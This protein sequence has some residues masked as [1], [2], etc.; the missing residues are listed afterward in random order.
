MR[1]A[2]SP[3]FG[4]ACSG[5]LSPLFAYQQAVR[6][7]TIAHAPL[8]LVGPGG[9]NDH[10][11]ACGVPPRHRI[12]A[13]LGTPRLARAALRRIAGGIERIVCWS[14]E[15]ATLAV[16]I[17]E[18]TELVST[19][20]EL[21]LLPTRRLSGVTCLNDHDAA[22]WSQRGIAPE[23]SD[24]TQPAPPAKHDR[25][26][27]RARLGVDDRTLLFAAIADQPTAADAR[28]MIFMLTVLHAT[29]FPVQA[30][31]PRNAYNAVAA[32]R[33]HRATGQPY[34]LL[35]TERP[36]AEWLTAA[37]VAVLPP[38]DRSGADAVLESA[39]RGFGCEIIRL[40]AHGKPS[41][42]PGWSA[43]ADAE[44]DAER[45]LLDRLDG[46]VARQFGAA[47]DA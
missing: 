20:P 25:A 7:G 13:P 28:G 38:P 37:D 15:L 40:D 6:R 17:A 29:G 12:T 42:R 14:D 8:T 2:A 36:P 31:V 32:R 21:C 22:V 47:A 41:T 27:L 35:M 45:S 3:A 10:A 19:R 30:I 34:P 18:H 5:R 46:M 26:A 11:A 16:G 44:P 4:P 23:I 39:C 33:H 9:A 43:L 24:R 1:L